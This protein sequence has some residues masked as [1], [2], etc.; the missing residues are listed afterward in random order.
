MTHL[1]LADISSRD[2][3]VEISQ[4]A[5]FVVA[6]CA[7]LLLLTIFAIRQKNPS[8][9]L[10]LFVCFSV[11]IGGTSLTLATSG[12]NLVANSPTGPTDRQSDVSFWLCDRELNLRSYPAYSQNYLGSP[13]RFTKNDVFYYQGI[14][15]SQSDMELGTI[16][17]DLNG[18]L[19]N[20]SMVLPL[21]EKQPF[22]DGLPIGD[23]QKFINTRKDGI[24]SNAV[25]NTSCNDNQFAEV[26]LFEFIYDPISQDFKQRKIDQ[27][28]SYVLSDN[29][30]NIPTC[31]LVEF[32]PS[33]DKTDKFC[34]SMGENQ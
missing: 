20:A 8:Y 16:A 27:V 32:A 10:P 26:Q 23:L 5:V 7:I 25:S 28:S 9:K 33:K 6:T 11:L 29:Q 34:K 15:T 24:Y 19:S 30:T 13:V 4:T 18:Y 2:A 22:K 17:D 12:I 31:I 21:K 14:P 1:Y 3:V